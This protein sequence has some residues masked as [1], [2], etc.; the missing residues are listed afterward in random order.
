MRIPAI[1]AI[2]ATLTACGPSEKQLEIDRAKALAAKLTC[3]LPAGMVEHRP[4][5]GLSLTD[6]G[7]KLFR[8]YVELERRKSG[9]PW[10]L[11]ATMAYMEQSDLAASKGVMQAD[12]EK[13]QGFI[14]NYEQG[15]RLFQVPLDEIIGGMVPI[16]EKFCSSYIKAN[17]RLSAQA[18]ALE[19]LRAEPQQPWHDLKKRL[20]CPV[21]QKQGC[22][23]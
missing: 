6:A 22:K 11:S 1:L 14:R 8:E 12:A 13:A 20:P 23:P 18:Q 5:V 16:Y 4:L 21:Q 10:D 2:A 7:E 15:K 9:D 19:K 3:V 17:Q